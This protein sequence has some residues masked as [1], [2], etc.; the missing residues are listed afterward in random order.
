MNN[1]MLKMVLIL[2]RYELLTCQGY[3]PIVVAQP[4]TI[5]VDPI[6]FGTPHSNNIYTCE[7]LK[8]IQSKN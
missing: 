5:F 6:A 3:S 7:K 2:H 1:N 4:P 8:G